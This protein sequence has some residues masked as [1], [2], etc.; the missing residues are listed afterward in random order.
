MNVIDPLKLIT[1][2][3]DRPSP[4]S[5][6]TLRPSPVVLKPKLIQCDLARRRRSDETKSRITRDANGDVPFIRFE[7]VG[8]TPGELAIKEDVAD[9]VLR[10]DLRRNDI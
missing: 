10:N 5:P 4:T 1:D 8:S 3:D 7:F 9:R 6:I 2:T